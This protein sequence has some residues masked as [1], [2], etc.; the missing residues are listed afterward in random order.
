MDM[1]P[2]DYY[3]SLRNNSWNELSAYEQK[4][5]VLAAYLILDDIGTLTTESEVKEFLQSHLP[6]HPKFW[7]EEA[8]NVL[9]G[10]REWQFS[11]ERK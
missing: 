9:Y 4:R 7:N 10:F 8:D 2:W 1:S 11:R 6:E 5:I 3:L